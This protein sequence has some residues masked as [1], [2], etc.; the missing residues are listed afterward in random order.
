MS[1]RTTFGFAISRLLLVVCA[2]ISVACASR[3]HVGTATWNGS[4][5]D[6]SRSQFVKPP[7]FSISPQEV[8]SRYGHLCRGRY[9]CA[10]AADADNYYLV[11]DGGIG[12]SPWKD[13]EDL[14][15]AIVDG[16]TGQLSKPKE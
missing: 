1:Y 12:L 10:Y 13:L 16:R 4:S 5:L 8:L 15:T 9:L 7:H 14:A 3:V 6:T 11:P 2:L